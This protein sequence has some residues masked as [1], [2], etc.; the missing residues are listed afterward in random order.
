MVASEL[1]DEVFRVVGAEVSFDALHRLSTLQS[2]RGRGLSRRPPSSPRL[3]S[4]HGRIFRRSANTRPGILPPGTGESS[5]PGRVAEGLQVDHVARSVSHAIANIVRR[6]HPV[7]LTVTTRRSSST[8]GSVAAGA[9]KS[10][11]VVG[12]RGRCAQ[13]TRRW[14]SAFGDPGSAGEL[15]QVC[16]WFRAGA[17]CGIIFLACAHGR[18]RAAV[19][20]CGAVIPAVAG[21]WGRA[22]VVVARAWRREHREQVCRSAGAGPDR[23]G[24]QPRGLPPAARIPGSDCRSPP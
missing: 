10:Q 21:S 2:P 11:R 17:E 12:R 16:G 15:S 3:V 19:A 14:C 24:T 6:P 7:M 8:A 4:P 20:M 13:T 22:R 18:A 5:A 1:G 23:V 9:E